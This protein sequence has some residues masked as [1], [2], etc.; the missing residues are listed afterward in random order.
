MKALSFFMVMVLCV[1]FCY[2]DNEKDKDIQI[3]ARE[4][5][6]IKVWS[7][8]HNYFA[9]LNTIDMLKKIRHW[10]S[11][12]NG[13]QTYVKQ[14][15]IDQTN[16][17]INV[18]SNPNSD[19]GE[20]GAL[21]LGESAYY[22]NRYNAD[23]GEAFTESEWNSCP[24]NQHAHN[25]PDLAVTRS[26]TLGYHFARNS[27]GWSG[28]DLQVSYTF[29]NTEYVFYAQATQTP[30]V[31]DLDGDGR[32]EASNGKWLPHDLQAKV[33]ELVSFDINGDG[34]AEKTEWIGKNDG[35]LVEYT[36]GEMTAKNLFGSE[37]GRYKNGFEKLSLYD[38]NGDSKLTGDELST[39][40]VWQ[41]KNSNAKVDEGEISSLES[42]GITEIKI[43]HIHCVS[44]FI[45]N[46]ERKNV[47]D[48][49]PRYFEVKRTK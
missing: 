4:A 26:Y 48:W 19:L 38:K 36:G 42:L 49:Y 23:H 47:W 6:K 34:F 30:I 40:S 10:A 9:G 7:S 37:G 33:S 18:M 45:Q 25:T 35:L 43:N 1:S 8:N 14:T 22:N 3:P 15:I 41:D 12:A 11:I 39:L 5:S 44:S 21:N 17:W 16:F 29:D 31:L 28:T 27:Q 32:L 20:V 13:G 24:A 46:G 2:A